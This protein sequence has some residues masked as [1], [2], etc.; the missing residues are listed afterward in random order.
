MT[1]WQQMT[2]L[3]T[4]VYANR[5]GVDL[6]VDV[7]RPVGK[8]KAAVLLLHGGAWRRGSRESV[9][10]SARALAGHG[11]VALAVQYRLLGQSPWP[12]QIQDV[13]SAIRWARR[14][15]A[16]LGVDTDKIV[17]EGLSAGGHL[18]L[19]AA[20]A[21]HVGAFSHDE[22]AD[23]DNSVAAVIAFYPPAEFQLGTP[24]DGAISASRLLEEKA[25]AR[26]AELASP[27][28]HAGPHFPPTCLFH[29]TDDHIVLPAASMRL[30]DRLRAAGTAVDLHLL[31]GQT[32]AFAML[33]SVV[34]QVQGTVAAFL[35]KHL[36]DPQ[37]YIEE[38][39]KLNQFAV[40]G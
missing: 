13:N 18:A 25:D 12:A 39:L 7:Y 15:A 37:F 36:V 22:D 19:L 35:D 9:A 8:A 5:N 3:E 31:S 27:I 10:P 11:F 33:P 14:N 16:N 6:L 30:F 23:Q 2:S 20:G 28:H 38:N 21:A 34:P 40:R 29:G 32:H 4:L 1:G 17:V 24:V 26:E